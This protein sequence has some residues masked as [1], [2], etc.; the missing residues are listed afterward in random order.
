MLGFYIN[1]TICQAFIVSSPPGET[2][3]WAAK[4]T[5]GGSEMVWSTVWTAI[6][7]IATVFAAGGILL[8]LKQMRFD[9]WLKAQEIFTNDEFVKARTFVFSHFDNPKDPWPE[10]KGENE[11]TVCRKMDEMAYLKGAIG[12]KKMFRVWGHPIAKAWLLLEPTVNTDRITSHWDE[13]W[14]TFAAVGRK[15][16]GKHRKLVEFRNNVLAQHNTSQGA[17]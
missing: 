7:A 9:A 6:G 16:V 8:A 13:K 4:I 2:P 11:K 5:I 10:I 3:R 17:K 1:C 15:A 14:C 12:C